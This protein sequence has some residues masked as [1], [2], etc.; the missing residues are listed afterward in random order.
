MKKMFLFGYIHQLGSTKAPREFVHVV[1][2]CRYV[3]NE[4]ILLAQLLVGV[5]A[6]TFE[7]KNEPHL[8]PLFYTL[9]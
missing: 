6:K 3:K 9:V 2:V 7:Y 1:Q 4:N 5:F 8:L